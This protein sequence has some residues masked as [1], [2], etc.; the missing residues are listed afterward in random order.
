MIVHF[1]DTV[2]QGDT[3]ELCVG[4]VDSVAEVQ[5]QL[6]FTYQ[7]AKSVLHP[8]QTVNMTVYLTTSKAE[9]MRQLFLEA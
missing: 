3:Y 8:T 1:D 2:I 5:D 7:P 4:A 6:G 9:K